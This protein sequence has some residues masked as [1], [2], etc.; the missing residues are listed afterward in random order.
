MGRSE[1]WS[2]L[3]SSSTRRAEQTE[4]QGLSERAQQLLQQPEGIDIDWKRDNKVDAVDLVAFANSP[5]GGVVLLGIEQ[6]EGPN[7]EQRPQICGCRVGDNAVL[8]V[9]NKAKDCLQPIH[10]RVYTE[11]LGQ[12]NKPFLRVEIPSGDH[13]PYCTK[14]GVY[15][16]RSQGRN[17]ALSPPQLLAILMEVEGQKFIDNFR[18]ATE[19]MSKSLASMYTDLDKQLMELHFRLEDAARD[20]A[21]QTENLE[22]QMSSTIDEVLEGLGRVSDQQTFETQ[23]QSDYLEFRLRYLETGLTALLHAHQL[24]DGQSL[25]WRPRVHE[26]IDQLRAEQPRMRRQSIFDK[27]CQLSRGECTAVILHK[28]C[29]E[30]MGDFPPP[31]SKPRKSKTRRPR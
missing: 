28:L 14:S 22:S 7:G 15:T 16:I 30:K 5:H 27:V 20:I 10:V 12:G 17:A 6:V 11:N 24:D 25:Y 3:V 26:W 9:M 19:E 1:V 8:E 29:V 21:A 2:S 23:E 18:R 4:F 31:W 13:R